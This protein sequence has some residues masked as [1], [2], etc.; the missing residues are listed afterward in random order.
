MDEFRP[1]FQVD[2]LFQSG[3]AKIVSRTD[4]GITLSILPDKARLKSVNPAIRCAASIRATVILDPKTYFPRHI[5][6]EVAE[7]GLRS[8]VSSPCPVRNHSPQRSA[9]E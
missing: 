7:T 1:A 8:A 9:A 2:A 6:G 3:Q 5:D 4:E